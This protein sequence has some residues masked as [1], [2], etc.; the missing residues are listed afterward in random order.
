MGLRTT[1]Q[2]CSTKAGSGAPTR[3]SVRLAHADKDAVRGTYNRGST[4]KS[5][6][7]CISGGVTISTACALVHRWRP[8]RDGQ[9]VAG[10][11]PVVNMEEHRIAQPCV[12]IGRPPADAAARNRNLSREA[13]FRD[14]AV[15]SRARQ[16]VRSSTVRR[17][18]MRSACT[19]LSM[20]TLATLL[21]VAAC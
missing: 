11:S 19:G 20:A 2:P 7:P 6:S 1:P 15:E 4:G 8:V 14:L 9:Y 5:G 16:P 13:A 10:P 18:R 17:R 21:N 3:S 12:Q